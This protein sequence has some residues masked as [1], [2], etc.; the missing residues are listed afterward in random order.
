MADTDAAELVSVQWVWLP[1]WLDSA[2]HTLTVCIAQV[3]E[4]TGS[5]IPQLFALLRQWDPAT[6]SEAHTIIH[7]MLQLGATANDKDALTD[8]TLL[9]YAVSAGANGIATTN[10]AVN[11][12]SELIDLVNRKFHVQIGVF[13]QSHTHVL[14][15]GADVNAQSQWTDMTPLHLGA[16]FDCPDIVRVL[17]Q[18]GHATID[19]RTSDFDNSTA[20]HLAAA[21]R[22]MMHVSRAIVDLDQ[23]L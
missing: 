5:S 8:M 3:L 23:Q 15:Q 20:L 13:C 21:G 6:Q 18:R 10:D 7:R 19:T 1:A 16:Y 4:N 9:H 11:L 22:M 12:V 17:I 14:A 2:R